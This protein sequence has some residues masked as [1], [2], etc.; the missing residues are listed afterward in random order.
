MQVSM[1]TRKD[2]LIRPRVTILY[3]M[4]VLERLIVFHEYYL[5]FDICSINSQVTGNYFL[6][7]ELCSIISLINGVI[8]YDIHDLFLE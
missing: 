6:N 3:V 8:N 7:F 4:T 2:F 1:K 5:L